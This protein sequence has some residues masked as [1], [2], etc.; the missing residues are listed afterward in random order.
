MLTFINYGK[1]FLFLDFCVVDLLE[2]SQEKEEQHLWKV[3]FVN[4]KMLAKEGNSVIGKTFSL[5]T[6]PILSRKLPNKYDH[7]E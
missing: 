4:N 1:L 3:D 7:M 6:N 5:D 2:K